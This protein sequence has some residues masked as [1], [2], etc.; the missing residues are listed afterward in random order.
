M[1]TLIATVIPVGVIP[2]VMEMRYQGAL[3]RKVIAAATVDAR[4]MRCPSPIGRQLSGYQDSQPCS[5]SF[6][7]WKS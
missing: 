4:I 3:A 7:L 5:L 6:S 1:A 2:L